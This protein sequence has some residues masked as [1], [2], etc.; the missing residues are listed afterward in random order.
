MH[1]SRP[2]SFP[3]RC[4]LAALFVCAAALSA[5]HG[6]QN[7]GR[8]V[9][10]SFH[11]RGEPAPRSLSDFRGRLIA[12]TVWAPDCSGCDHQAAALHTLSKRFSSDGILCLVLYDRSQD[13]PI[14]GLSILHGALDSHQA[15]TLPSARPITLLLDR[16]GRVRAEYK[17][18]RD[19]DDLAADI[20][21]LLNP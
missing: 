7:P 21:R 15:A 12:L 4:W 5:C 8:E 1:S 11:V 6:L 3:R 20:A 19:A 10:A 18:L 16:Q 2:S 17:R 13:F 9:N 14:S